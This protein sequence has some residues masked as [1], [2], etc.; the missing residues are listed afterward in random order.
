MIMLITRFTMLN[1]KPHLIGPYLSTIGDMTTLMNSEGKK[2]IEDSHPI[3]VSD[4][5]KR[6]F[7]TSDYAAMESL[8]Y[9][10]EKATMMAE[11]NP[12]K[13]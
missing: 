11:K 2:M 4:C 6:F 3:L 9:I 8:T 5:Y 7:S 10:A 12:Q 13:I 1:T